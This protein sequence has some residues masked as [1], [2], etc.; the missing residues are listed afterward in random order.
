MLK[1]WKILR[2][3]LEI[4]GGI[5]LIIALF[6]GYQI[7]SKF[8]VTRSDFA[9]KNDVMFIL[10][11][12]DIGKESNIIEILHSY[13]SSRNITEDHC[14]AYCIKIDRFPEN[15]VGGKSFE[16]KT[17]IKGPVFDP[18]LIDAVK[19]AC[20]W[21]KSDNQNWFPTFEEINSSRF[22]LSFPRYSGFNDTIDAV[23]MIAY[24]TENNLLYYSDSSW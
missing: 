16:D 7:F 12:R 8:I 17:W 2:V 18:I 19:N 22:Y 14:D 9:K 15:I 24:D 23:Q 6:L 4:W 20:G 5:S 10:N 3:G 1:F 21:P 13:K 11:W